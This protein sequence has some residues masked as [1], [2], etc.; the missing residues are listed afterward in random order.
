MLVT[1]D[2][3][4]KRAKVLYHHL[5]A[6]CPQILQVYVPQTNNLTVFFHHCTTFLCFFFSLFFPLQTKLDFGSPKPPR[7]EVLEEEASIDFVFIPPETTKERVLTE[8]QKEVKRT[9]RSDLSFLVVNLSDTSNVKKTLLGV[10]LISFIYFFYFL[11]LTSQ[12]CITTLMLLWIPRC[13]ASTHKA[14]KIQCKFKASVTKNLNKS[15]LS[16]KAGFID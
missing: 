14:K 8:H 2:D 3:Q 1:A 7:R 11:G 10:E 5:H 15:L 12:P 4:Y 16:H 6:I 9:K 13:S